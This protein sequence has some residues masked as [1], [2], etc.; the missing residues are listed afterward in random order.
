MT[1]KEKLLVIF[2]RRSVVRLI[3]AQKD[4]RMFERYAVPA[5][6]GFLAIDDKTFRID[7]SNPLYGKKNIPTYM[8]YEEEAS[9]VPLV[10]NPL[11]WDQKTG[12]P[13][14]M[15]RAINQQLAKS[16]ISATSDADHSQTILMAL[17]G[18]VFVAL[19][20]MAFFLNEQ[21]SDVLKAIQEF[22]GNS[23]GNI[24]TP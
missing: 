9:S 2:R 13:E 23:N 14:E 16:I 11:N 1:F 15:K 6:N 5:E 24:P 20:A 17:I 10:V 19:I 3:I 21:L 4:H 18:A 22:N 7:K 8:F 12:S